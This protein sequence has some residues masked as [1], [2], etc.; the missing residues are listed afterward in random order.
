MVENCSIIGDT[1]FGTFETEITCATC[2]IQTYIYKSFT[3]LE[4][5]LMDIS[6]YKIMINN[7]QNLENVI[8]INLT[9]RPTISSSKY[10]SSQI[11]MILSASG[12]YVKLVA[13]CQLSA[14]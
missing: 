8:S 13:S 6:N 9:K 4:F 11:G 10:S 2:N 7:Y 1:F 12:Q 3:Y 5:P 14:S